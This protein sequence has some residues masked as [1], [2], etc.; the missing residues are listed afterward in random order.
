M[1][2]PSPPQSRP[3]SSDLSPSEVAELTVLFNSGHL[4]S[5]RLKTD[6]QDRLTYGQFSGTLAAELMAAESLLDNSYLLATRQLS[7]AAAVERERHRHNAS[8]YASVGKAVLEA[9]KK[10]DSLAFEQILKAFNAR[11]ERTPLPT[12]KKVSKAKGAP[13]RPFALEVLMPKVLSFILSRR[14]A[15]AFHPKGTTVTASRITKEE[16]TE[17]LV[18]L[19]TQRGSPDRGISA[20]QLRQWIQRAGIGKFMVKGSRG[21]KKGVRSV[22]YVR[23]KKGE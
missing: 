21:R 14:V 18:S 11:R 15:D 3:P 13:L 23:R 4:D 10:N 8:V 22:N 7:S 1:A 5:L 17:W 16:I 2:K 12:V 20:S 9:F 19:Q 6:R